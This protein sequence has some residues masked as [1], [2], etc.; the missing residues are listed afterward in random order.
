MTGVSLIKIYFQPGTDANADVTQVSN[1]AMGGPAKTAAGHASSS[2]HEGA[3]ASSL[4]VCLLTVS[5]G[6]PR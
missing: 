3:D 5:G 2:G 4:P 6:R 1:L